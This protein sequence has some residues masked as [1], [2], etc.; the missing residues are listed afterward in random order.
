LRWKRFT[1]LDP[2]YRA[3]A[4]SQGL[5]APPDRYS[6]ACGGP[7]IVERYALSITSPRGGSRF[8]LDPEMPAGMSLLPIACRVEPA[9]ASVLW[10]AD[11]E[12]VAETGYPFTLKW[13][14]R[15]GIHTFQAVVPG[16]SFRSA[17]VRLEVQ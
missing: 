5:E 14:M 7:S 1:V 11:G 4:E 9:P 16:T 10:L 15:P 3:W 6:P 13:A 17:P 2:R 12:E 8:F